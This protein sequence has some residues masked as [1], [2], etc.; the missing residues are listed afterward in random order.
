MNF[1]YELRKLLE[2]H[3][4]KRYKPYTDTVGK[5]SIGIGRNLSDNGISDTEIDLMYANDLAA[6]TLACIQLFSNYSRL[7]QVRQMVLLDMAF[8]LGQSK[9]SKFV[10]TIK[11]VED[12]NFKMAAQN[13]LKSKWAEQTGSRATQLAA[14]MKTGKLQ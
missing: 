3:E 7:D 4:G 12:G 6:A 5:L 1:A 2:S 10:N 8:N 11:Y 13:M 14:M 9:L